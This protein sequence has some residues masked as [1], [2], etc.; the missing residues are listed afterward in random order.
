MWH[1]W[2]VNANDVMMTWFASYAILVTSD[3]ACTLHMHVH[4]M[5]ALNKYGV[6]KYPSGLACT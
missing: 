3:W 2:N 4:G 6:T 1:E 5:Q